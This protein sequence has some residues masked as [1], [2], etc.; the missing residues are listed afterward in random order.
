[1]ATQTHQL[2]WQ[3]FWMAKIQTKQPELASKVNQVFASTQASYVTLT[4]PLA[5][6]LTTSS[7]LEELK[8]LADNFKQL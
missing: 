7:G 2:N 5:L 6:A 3:T 4:M 1:M 8:K